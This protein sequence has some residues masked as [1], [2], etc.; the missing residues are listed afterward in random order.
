MLANRCINQM[1]IL[2]LYFCN[3]W[4]LRRI[5]FIPSPNH[6]IIWRRICWKLWCRK[7][8]WKFQFPHSK[9]HNSGGDKED[10]YEN[11]DRKVNEATGVNFLDTK[12]AQFLRCQDRTFDNTRTEKL[13]A[14]ASACAWAQIVVFFIFSITRFSKWSNNQFNLLYLIVLSRFQLQPDVQCPSLNHGRQSTHTKER[15]YHIQLRH[16]FHQ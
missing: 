14:K 5:I 9:H 11:N 6:L 15:K 16:H 2:L 3:F 1:I 4:I 12:L 8:K 13:S 10:N 7:L